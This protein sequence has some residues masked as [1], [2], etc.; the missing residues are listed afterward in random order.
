MIITLTPSHGSLRRYLRVI[1]RFNNYVISAYVTP[2]GT[3]FLLLHD[4][5]S[6]DSVRMYFTECHELF[7]KNMMNPFAQFGAPIVS[8]SFDN[9]I[10]AI[11]KRTLQL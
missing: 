6:E 1:D 11:A 5:R 10:K 2:G 3:H 8:R 4:G 7:V 9:H